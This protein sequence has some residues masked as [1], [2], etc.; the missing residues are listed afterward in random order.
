MTRRLSGKVAIITGGAAKLGRA[1]A[2]AFASEG[3]SLFLVGRDAKSLT[4]ATEA[5]T[6]TPIGVLS[7]DLT[8]KGAAERVVAAAKERFGHVDILVNAAGAFFWKKLVSLSEDDWRVTLDTNLSAPFFLTQAFAREQIASQRGGA[9]INIASIHGTVPDGNVVPQ[10]AAKLGLIG[11]TRACAEALRPHGI[12]VNAISPG[13]IAPNSGSALST[14]LLSK[15][16]QGD[17][18]QMALYLASD[19]AAAI[20]GTNLEAYG[21]TRP[22]VAQN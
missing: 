22:V 3:A 8:G 9:V 10:C 2:E 1:I 6:G 12:R 14:D 21:V 5:L 17:V 4:G 20:T 18:A 15:V 11:L 13:A 16:T 7:I 19:S